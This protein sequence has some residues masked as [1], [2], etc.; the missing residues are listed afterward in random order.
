MGVI[1]DANV[2]IAAER[3]EWSAR[4]FLNYLERILP[5]EEFE[6]PATVAAELIHG[7]FRA[8][9]PQQ[10]Q[11]RSTFVEEILHV[12]PTIIFTKETAWIAGRIRGEQAKVGNTLPF[13]DSLIAAT[14]LELG[15]AVLTNNLKDFVRIPGLQV[16]PF[17]IQP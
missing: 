16:I 8:K 2:F 3:R 14:A 12:I 15:S 4:R 9:I 17:S 1:I 10:A 5:A 6:L 11:I 7:I 13:A